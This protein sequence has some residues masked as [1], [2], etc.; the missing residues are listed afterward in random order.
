MNKCA[1]CGREYEGLEGEING[2]PFCHPA[3][4][5]EYEVTCYKQAVWESWRFRD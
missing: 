4:A 5:D 3:M 2:T 1:R